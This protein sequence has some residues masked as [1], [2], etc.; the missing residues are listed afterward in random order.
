MRQ[1]T[2]TVVFLAKRTPADN[3]GNRLVV[4]VD[5]SIDV[6]IEPTAITNDNLVVVSRFDGARQRARVVAVPSFRQD[7]GSRVEAL[8][9]VVTFSRG[10]KA[11]YSDLR[12]SFGGRHEGR[13]VDEAEEVTR[14]GEL[15]NSFRL[16]C[17]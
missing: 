13:G 9:V 11:L 6:A 1:E 12:E 5:W 7:F 16:K 17:D 8:P 3:G 2:E 15:V 10:L 14:C 4:R